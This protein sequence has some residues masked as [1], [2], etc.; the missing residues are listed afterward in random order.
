M[1]VKT[2]LQKNLCDSILTMAVTNNKV[3]SINNNSNNNNTTTNNNKQ[4]QQQQ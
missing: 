4:Q 1:A 3:R 2:E